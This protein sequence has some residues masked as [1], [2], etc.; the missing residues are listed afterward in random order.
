MNRDPCWIVESL[1]S[2]EGACLGFGRVGSGSFWSKGLAGR[3]SLPWS[4]HHHVPQAALG[5]NPTSETRRG[6]GGSQGLAAAARTPQGSTK[7]AIS[8]GA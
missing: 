5:P 8:Q 2:Q 3:G 4:P 7:G 1:T 6:L